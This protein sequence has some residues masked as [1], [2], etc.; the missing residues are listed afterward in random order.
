MRGGTASLTEV[1]IPQGFAHAGK[2][3]AELVIPKDAVVISITRDGELIVPRGNTQILVN[4]KVVVLA[5]N[6]AFHELAQSWNLADV[7]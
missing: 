7:K 5:K 2:T 3:L 1:L 6:T 4:D